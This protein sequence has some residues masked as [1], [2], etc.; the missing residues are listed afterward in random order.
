MNQDHYQRVRGV[1]VRTN[2]AVE[3][4]LVRSGAKK[5]AWKNWPP[6]AM[7]SAVG[8]AFTGTPADLWSPSFPTNGEFPGREQL[9]LSGCDLSGAIFISAHFNN[10][11]MC[12]LN[13]ANLRGAN[14]ARTHW[15]LIN[16]ENADL[17]DADLSECVIQGMWCGGTSFRHAN[18][19]NA[20]ISLIGFPA[21][22]S[23]ADLTNAFIV[24][25]GFNTKYDLAKAKVQG[26]RVRLTKERDP[27]EKLNL[28][29]F[30]ASLNE[31]QRTQ[32]VIEARDPNE[33]QYLTDLQSGLSE[34]Q[35]IQIVLGESKKAPNPAGHSARPWWRFWR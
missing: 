7:E 35:R 6:Q 4:L 25:T 14:L 3:G 12:P 20:R 32:I 26:C 10:G 34:R 29:N 22:L 11:S 13:R 2:E 17:T 8:Q 9:D 19:S 33:R 16:M 24:M 21:N 28:T 1:S 30:I 15:F 27:I 5:D 18:L 31:E 23:D